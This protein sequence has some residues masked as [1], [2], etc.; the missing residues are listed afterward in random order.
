MKPLVGDRYVSWLQAE[1]SAVS[2][3]P[4]QMNTLTEKTILDSRKE[5]MELNPLFIA[6]SQAVS[7]SLFSS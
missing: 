2:R 5:A 3:L 1:E 6:Q 4:I 7:P